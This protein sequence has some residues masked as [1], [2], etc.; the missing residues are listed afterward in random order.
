MP[1]HKLVKLYGKVDTIQEVIVEDDERHYGQKV[2]NIVF[3]SEFHVNTRRNLN[4][5]AGD[6]KQRLIRPIKTLKCFFTS[7]H[8]KEYEEDRLLDHFEEFGIIKRYKIID[9]CRGQ[10]IVAYIEYEN[11]EDARKARFWSNPRYRATYN[12]TEELH[13]LEDDPN[14]E[15]KEF[16]L[17]TSQMHNQN[18]A[19][20][21]QNIQDEPESTQMECKLPIQEAEKH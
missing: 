5:T 20:P 18:I 11:G 7:T 8:M 13:M 12:T 19:N 6:L 16:E 1:L 2:V 10:P 21:K 9:D 14:L 4:T 15:N 3:T 17:M